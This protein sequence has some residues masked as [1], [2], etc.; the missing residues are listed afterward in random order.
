MSFMAGSPI[1]SD[2]LPRMIRM[3]FDMEKAIAM[4]L[5]VVDK[6]LISGNVRKLR[7]ANGGISRRDITELIDKQ[8]PVLAFFGHC[9]I[10]KNTA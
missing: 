9:K 3:A 7:R 1:N 4:S 5:D 10:K 6:S 2:S 8:P